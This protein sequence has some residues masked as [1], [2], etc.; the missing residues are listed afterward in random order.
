M[1]RREALRKDAATCVLEYEVPGAEGVLNGVTFDAHR[2]VVASGWTLIRMAPRSGRIVGQLETHPSPGG[3]AY[4]GRYLWQFSQG[5]LQQLDVRTGLVVRSFAPKLDGVTGLECLEGDLLVLHSDGRALSRV[6]VVDRAEGVEGTVLASVAVPTPM[7]GLAWLHGELWTSTAGALLAV[8]PGS[9]RALARIELPPGV[10]A[11]D[12]A[13]D[14]EGRLWCVDGTSRFVRAFARPRSGEWRR[15]GPLDR[16][17]EEDA[18]SSHTPGET[19]VAGV[20]EAPLAAPDTTFHRI[21]VPVDFSVESRRALSA[22]LALNEGLGSEVHAF[23]LAEPGANDE[24]LAGTGAAPVTPS[25]LVEAAR[26]RLRRYVDDFFPAQAARVAIHAH[27]GG[28][29][30]RGIER[31]A[32]EIG[33]SLVLMAGRPRQSLLRTHM[34]KITRD[35]D[36]AV[37]VLRM[38]TAQAE[39]RPG[40]SEGALSWLARRRSRRSTASGRTMPHVIRIRDVV[41]GTTYEMSPDQQALRVPYELLHP[42]G[43]V[44]VEGASL[45]WA[46]G[47][48]LRRADFA[49]ALL[50]DCHP[51]ERVVVQ[52]T[53]E[54]PEAQW[55]LCDVE[56]VDGMMAD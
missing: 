34:E 52:L 7:R 44:R 53:P 30:V 41:R 12:L 24:F 40:P 10:E 35:L 4:D 18:W 20:T 55:W 2:L 13:G 28:D 29:V 48:T 1:N 32:R 9:A 19:A 15:P 45:E 11:C 27:F 42:E 47:Q 14:A 22:A 56:A 43:A 5:H 49:E 51:G 16:D 46:E 50:G 17:L 39:S 23:H 3:L 8:E 36:G 21:L 31:A 6:R 33:A 26:D 54:D 25:E 38:E 37:L